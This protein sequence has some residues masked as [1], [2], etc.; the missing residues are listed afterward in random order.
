M[1]TFSSG[2]HAVSAPNDFKLYYLCSHT[3]RGD[4]SRTSLSIIGGGEGTQQ[5]V[6]DM[7]TELY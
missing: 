2:Q 4:A 7:A 1:A 5:G 6:Y 3:Y